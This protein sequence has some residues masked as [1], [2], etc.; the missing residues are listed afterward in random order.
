MVWLST[1]DGIRRLEA[2]DGQRGPPLP[3]K[4]AS[5]STL[6]ELSPGRALVGIGDETSEMRAAL[7]EL[8]AACGSLRKR[9]A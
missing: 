5:A 4:L 7:V 1:S 8:D 2:A 9:G 6:L 3:E